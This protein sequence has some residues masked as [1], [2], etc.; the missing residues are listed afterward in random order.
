MRCAETIVLYTYLRASKNILVKGG[1]DKSSDRPGLQ[2]EVF[3]LNE[4]TDS[5]NLTD[6]FWRPVRDPW[7]SQRDRLEAAGRVISTWVKFGGSK[8]SR[9][10]SQVA[11]AASKSSG[12]A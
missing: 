3:R 7:A 6:A 8:R 2:K 12:F 10:E 11:R 5:M 1:P 9:R 4:I